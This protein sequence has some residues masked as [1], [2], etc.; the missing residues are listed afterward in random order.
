VPIV[1]AALADGEQLVRVLVLKPL[2]AQMFNLLRQRICHLSDRRLFYLP[3][4]RDVK[5]DVHKIQTI[6]DLFKECG[7]V[8]GVLVCQPE[9]ILSFQLMS[10]DTLCRDGDT[11]GGRILLD[12]QNWFDQQSRDILDESDEILSV[13][14]QLI[15]TVGTPTPLQGQ[16]NRWQTVQEI[17]TLLRAS[18]AGLATEFTEE[19]ELETTGAHRFPRTRILS[20]ECGR[21]LMQNMAHQIV[22]E[23]GMKSTPFRGYPHSLQAAALRFLTDI[24]VTKEE[25]QALKVHSPD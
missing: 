10:L 6:V 17:F 19:L 21:H 12:A 25:S 11:D 1:S 8:G 16:P 5:L 15:Y 23:G 9:H 4:S 7:R 3:F 22:F 18:L 24:A 2:C 13:R 14:Y 20:L